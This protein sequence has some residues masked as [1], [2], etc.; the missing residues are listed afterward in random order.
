MKRPDVQAPSPETQ[1]A[2]LFHRLVARYRDGLEPKQFQSVVIHRLHEG[3][4]IPRSEWGQYDT[5]EQVPSPETKIR[6][7]H[8]E[9]DAAR[10]RRL[11]ERHELPSDADDVTH[12]LKKMK[13][14]KM[15]LPHWPEFLA[16]VRFR[17]QASS[18]W[19]DIQREID[20][21]KEKFPQW[22]AAQ[23]EIATAVQPDIR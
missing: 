6:L 9:S 16:Q 20:K 21:L 14:G 10:E 13:K 23:I 11:L 3:G 7:E 17:F 1:L 15:G 18:D 8:A 19:A 4:I 2:D 22:A 12:M 5:R